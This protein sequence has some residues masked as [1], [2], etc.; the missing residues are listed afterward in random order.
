[1]PR[2]TSEAGSLVGKDRE[3]RGER[4]AGKRLEIDDVAGILPLFYILLVYLSFF[5]FFVSGLVR[6]LIDAIAVFLRLKRPGLYTP[7]GLA[8]LYRPLD[9]FWLNRVYQK[10]RDLF[11]RTVLS[12]PGPVLQVAERYSLD[13]NRTFHPTGKVLSMLNLGSYNYLG[14]AENS[15]SVIDSVAD[16][17]HHFSIA[18]ASPRNEAGNFE[19]LHQLESA[20]AEFVGKPAALVFG[21]GFATNSTTIPILC[22]GKGNLIISDS[23]NHN[24]IITGSKDSNHAVI[25]VFKHNDMKD[26]EQLL[27]NSIARG[28]P[29]SGRA[30][31]KIVIIVEGIYSMEGEI[32]KLPEIVALKKKYRA[33]LYVDEAHSIGALG[34]SGRGVCEYWGIHPDEV[35]LLMGTFTKA[36]GSV[37]GY[38]SG[39]KEMITFLRANSYGTLYATSMSPPC[40]Q[41]ALGALH[42]ISGKDGT[43]QGQ[44]RISNLRE[45]SNY[46]RRRLIEEGFHI[47]GDQDSPVILMMVYQVP[48]LAALSRT[49]LQ[50]GVAVVSVGF[51]VTPFLLNR[52]RFCISS[53]LTIDQI[54]EAVKTMSDFGEKMGLKYAKYKNYRAP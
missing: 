53:A 43:N 46:F 50:H 27:R 14:F 22:G 30:W 8:P 49:L 40:A 21:M 7:P 4:I 34:K 47:F 1:M 31:K 26:L 13:G 39:S 45:N 24:S 38:I 37:G 23:L 42:M 16:S 36:F 17:M 11:E 15:G 6:E 18:C 44:I 48:M 2:T 41:Q 52:I 9:Y 12:V 35:D 20:I 5:T 3:S 10:V 25:R 33:Y 19:I 28:Q 51:P 32:C 54:E 29:R